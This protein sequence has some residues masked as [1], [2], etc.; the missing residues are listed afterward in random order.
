MN[1]I[2][3]IR[4]LLRNK[5]FVAAVPIG[6][7]ILVF[8]STSDNPPQYVSRA[9]IYTGITSGNTIDE[10]ENTRVDF[11]KANAAYDNLINML[12]SRSVLKEVSIR[13]LA[14]HLALKEPDPAMIGADAYQYLQ[15][16][17][18]EQIKSEMGADFNSNLLKLKERISEDKNSFLYGVFNYQTRYY[19]QAV[20]STVAVKRLNSSDII[21]MSFQ[22]DDPGICKYTLLFLTEVVSKQYRSIKEE[23]SGEIYK[24]FK[25]QLEAAEKKLNS[26]EDMLQQFNV[27]HEII[28]YYEQTRFVADRNE[29]LDAEYAQEKMMFSAADSAMKRLEM[30]MNM[31]QRLVIRNNEIINKRNK[32]AEVT[33]KLALANATDTVAKSGS[34]LNELKTQ[35]EMLKGQLQED[36]STL[37]ALTYSDEGLRSDE[38]LLQWLNNMIKFEEG[39]ARLQIMEEYRTSFLKRYKLFAPLGAEMKR[40]ERKI[41]VNEEEYLTILYG[42]NLSKLKQQ[43]IEMASHLKLLDEPYL[44]IKP[45]PSKR[46]LLIV[47]AFLAGLLLAVAVVFF[48]SYFDSTI[49]T[50]SNASKLTGLEVV[51]LFAFEGKNHN[52]IHSTNQALSNFLI[53]RVL[54][55]RAF[56]KPRQTTYIS[57]TSTRRHEGKT[58]VCGRLAQPLE[59]AGFKLLQVNYTYPGE[60]TGNMADTYRLQISPDLLRE[61]SLI[62]SLQKNISN[63]GEYDYVLIEMPSIIDSSFPIHLVRE[64]NINLL[65]C[66][67]KRSWKNSDDKALQMLH[68]AGA[69]KISLVLNGIELDVS[70][71][72]LGE[73]DKKRSWFRIKLKQLVGLEFQ[74]KKISA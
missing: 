6:M 26:S 27:N 65:V 37:S 13:L 48:T 42:L 1:L 23:Q 70:E 9:T 66:N 12:K 47:S 71:A 64:M 2:D 63:T 19:S 69:Q 17:V 43:S 53:K 44:P 33:H 18:P 28:N 31:R 38:L 36:I 21:E 59:N 11:F 49:R 55:H 60:E 8:M 29:K 73:C 35:S 14:Q 52:N 24:Y 30:S 46:K 39:K 25:E 7:A 3:F 54:M 16:I 15:Q 22:S 68:E 51:G 5:Y 34:Q 41:D 45:I 58:F 40:I 57:V 62:Q 56:E 4:L 74:S 72:F 20:L 32:L 50:P 61:T 10:Q 67:A